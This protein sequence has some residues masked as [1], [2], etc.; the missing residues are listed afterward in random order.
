M[1]LELFSRQSFLRPIFGRTLTPNYWEVYDIMSTF[2]QGFR[3]LVISK[4][5]CPPC[6]SCCSP[7]VLLACSTFLILLLSLPIYLLTLFSSRLVFPVTLLYFPLLL[8]L[9]TAHPA[10]LIGKRN[11]N[12]FQIWNFMEHWQRFLVWHSVTK[13]T[14]Y[15]LRFFFS[16][17]RELGQ[18]NNKFPCKIEPM[19]SKR[20]FN[21]GKT[22][23][24]PWK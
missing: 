4:Y 12:Y 9:L 18:T 6:S 23:L 20:K 11:L 15:R 21:V 2:G 13:S 3:I 1:L 10:G 7:F 14:N 22:K 17:I 8:P 5:G 19:M 24:V 16:I